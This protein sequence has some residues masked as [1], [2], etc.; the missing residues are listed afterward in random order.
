MICHKAKDQVPV[1][2]R[3]VEETP[4][5]EAG[6]ETAAAASVPAATV[7]VPDAVIEAR[8]PGGSNV[9]G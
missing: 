6:E 7:Y 2:V 8:I 9:P 5:E 4:S 3:G 1:E